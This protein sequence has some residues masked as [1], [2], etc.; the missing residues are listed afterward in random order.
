MATAKNGVGSNQYQTRTGN[1]PT[2]AG[3]GVVAAAVTDTTAVDEVGWAFAPDSGGAWAW[4]FPDHPTARDDLRVIGLSGPKAMT[5]LEARDRFG[6]VPPEIP[7]RTWAEIK[8]GAIPS[9]VD[10]RH[11][12][13][14]REHWGGLDQPEFPRTD[15]VSVCADESTGRAAVEIAVDGRE[16]T[17]VEVPD[18]GDWQLIAKFNTWDEEAPGVLLSKLGVT[19]DADVACRYGEALNEMYNAWNRITW[20]DG[21]NGLTAV[22]R[23]THNEGGLPPVGGAP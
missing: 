8:S 2:R 16:V 5:A 12:D 19:N 9:A 6:D 3:T 21:A 18:I 10:H 15:F 13:E 22:E 20:S 14:V 1:Q 11:V 7:F 23:Q 4:A 17:L